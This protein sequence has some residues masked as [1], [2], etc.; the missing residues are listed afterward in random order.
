MEL[1]LQANS[2]RSKADPRETKLA[3]ENEA[4]KKKLAKKDNVIA[5]ISEE[6]VTLKKELGEP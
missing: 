4:L 5:A 2:R 1:A 6:F 3:V